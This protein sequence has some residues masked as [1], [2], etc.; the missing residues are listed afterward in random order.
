M[1]LEALNNRFARRKSNL[2]EIFSPTLSGDIVV[3]CVDWEETK[4]K[5][6]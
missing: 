3:I 4:I 2:V 5:Y 6:T 1:N